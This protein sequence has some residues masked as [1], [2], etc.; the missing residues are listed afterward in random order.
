MSMGGIKLYAMNTGFVEFDK[1]IF[2]PGRDEGKKTRAPYPFFLIVQQK[3]NVLFDTGVHKDVIYDP[4]GRLGTVAEVFKPFYKSGEDVV[5]QLR[6]LGISEPEIKYVINSHL[7]LDHA[8]GNQFFSKSEFLV[9]KDELLWA[10]NPKSEEFGYFRADWDHHLNYKTIGGEVDIFGDGTVITLPLPGHTPG[11]QGLIVR[12]KETGTVILS[13]DCCPL[14]E[15]LEEELIPPINHDL[16]ESLLSIKKL[17]A[18]SQKE[19][20]T[21]FFGHDIE[22]WEGLKHPP[23]FYS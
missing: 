20:A 21:I 12:L 19:K 17:R 13:G 5:S 2:T 23:S 14:R 15:N 8:G 4:V 3:G 11:H 1:G 7:H 16:Q 18:L 9:Q 22:Q 10:M 6:S